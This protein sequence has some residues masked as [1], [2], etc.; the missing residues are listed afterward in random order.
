MIFSDLENLEIDGID[1]KDYP[2]FVD[3]FL[4]Y[5]ECNGKELTEKEYDFANENFTEEIHQHI[6]ENQ[7]YL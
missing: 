4:A 3:S 7:M 2:D 6:I 5:A 1:I